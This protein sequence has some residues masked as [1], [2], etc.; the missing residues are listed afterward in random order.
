M[1][2][3]FEH[4]LLLLGCGYYLLIA[5]GVVK[6]PPQRQQKFDALMKKRRVLLLVVAYILIGVLVYLIVRDLS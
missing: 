1:N 4:S 3:L 2:D 6:L 5:Y